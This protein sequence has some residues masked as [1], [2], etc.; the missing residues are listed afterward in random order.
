MQLKYFS[1]VCDILWVLRLHDWEKALSHWVQPK[2]IF[3]CNWLFYVSS[4]P[5]MYRVQPK[6]FSPECDIL[7]VLRPHDGEKALPQ[8]VHIKGFFPVCDLICLI[9]WPDQERA[10]LHWVHPKGFSPVCEILCFFM[11]PDLENPY[12]IGSSKISYLFYG[13]T[14]G[15]SV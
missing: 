3:S 6:C 9:R 14:G 5:L 11:S 10:L 12:H 15:S 4:V 13:T 2:R 8:W 7:C 1:P